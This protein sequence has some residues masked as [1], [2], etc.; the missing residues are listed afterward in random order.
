MADNAG[1]TSADQV[2]G[3]RG[4]ALLDALATAL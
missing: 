1:M 4:A 3:L 2:A